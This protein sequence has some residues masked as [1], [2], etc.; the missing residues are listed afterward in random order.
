MVNILLLSEEQETFIKKV[1]KSE[2]ILKLLQV[3]VGVTPDILQFK[4]TDHHDKRNFRHF[5]SFIL[6]SFRF[7]IICQSI[8]HK[9]LSRDSA[10]GTL[11]QQVLRKYEVLKKVQ[12]CNAPLLDALKSDSSM[13]LWFR[14]ND[15][16][17]CPLNDF[18]LSRKY[19]Q[20]TLGKED[21]ASK[22]GCC[23]KNQ[24]DPLPESEDTVDL[25]MC[26]RCKK[27]WYCSKEC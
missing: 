14:H 22:C 13:I 5:V 17:G 10:V 9:C 3:M 8:D 16:K 18:F 27:V 12:P 20:E 26:S 7:M 15:G 24:G 4:K 23:N 11:L 19:A 21:E 6:Q 2:I 1:L 25:K